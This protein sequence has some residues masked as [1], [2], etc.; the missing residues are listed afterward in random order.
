[1]QSYTFFR[2]NKIFIHFIAEKCLK[3]KVRETE[4][5]RAKER[6]DTGRTNPLS[7]FVWKNKKHEIFIVA[8][9]VRYNCCILQ[10]KMRK[11]F[12][13]LKKICSFKKFC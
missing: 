1:M 2:K 4:S 5:Q 10:E 8:G 11:K 3:M 13:F 7:D 12:F 9:K 6:V